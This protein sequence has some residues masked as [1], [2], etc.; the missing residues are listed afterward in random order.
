MLTFLKIVL[1]ILSDRNIFIVSSPMQLINLIEYKNLNQRNFNNFKNKRFFFGYATNNSEIDMMKFINKSINYDENEIVVLKNN[2]HRA[3]VLLLIKIRAI[4]SRLNLLIIGD[5]NSYLFNQFY[6]I[7]EKIIIL[8]DG[9]NIF[10]FNR[11]FKLDKGK[12]EIFTMFEKKQ[13]KNIEYLENKYRYLKSKLKKLKVNKSI[14]IL[15]SAGIEKKFIHPQKYIKILKNI[16]MKYKNYKIYYFPHP[17]EQKQN[18]KKFSFLN[19]L[20]P[21]TTIEL[22]LIEKK[23]KP[24]LIIG[25]NSTAFF[26]LKKIFGQKL[27]LIN[28]NFLR[29]PK[30][31]KRL[32]SIIS[33]NLKNKLKV[34]NFNFF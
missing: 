4:T 29:Y 16:K 25:F 13:F 20:N 31:Q 24:S 15:G 17:K 23:L 18:I 19:I 11:F 3:I 26:S 10:N 12:S 5:Y 7:S 22:Y 21:K 28:Y 33:L 30:N 1:Y 14:F 27:K 9:T 8:D 2:I 34:K 6:K 32:F